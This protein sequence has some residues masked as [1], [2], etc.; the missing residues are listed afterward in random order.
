M[1]TFLEQ[2]CEELK[3][4]MSREELN[5]GIAMDAHQRALSF[6]VG[7]FS[8]ANAY[9]STHPFPNPE[10]EVTYFKHTCPYILS[11][12]F[13]HQQVLSHVSQKQ[14][15]GDIPTYKA[16]CKRTLRSIKSFFSTHNELL[17]YRSSGHT[18]LDSK[19]FISTSDPHQK[20]F[21]EALFF[22]GNV[23]LNGYSII[24]GKSIAYFR[25]KLLVKQEL[26]R[27]ENPKICTDVLPSRYFSSDLA[28]T[29][30]KVNLVELAYALHAEGC[31]NNG[32]CDISQIMNGL[33]STFNVDVG[34]YYDIYSS[35]KQR[36]KPTRFILHLQEKLSQKI[37]DSLSV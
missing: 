29:S 7:I 37:E 2:K 35:I 36:K 30:S 32:D 12:I 5:D 34:N 23:T 10:S 21:E 3:K 20:L 16:H 11:E 22:L 33:E 26:N 28:W 13:F 25:F 4:E 9:V 24:I 1:N 19:Y 15:C 17:C 27:G 6:A 31:F 18:N 8:E 14:H